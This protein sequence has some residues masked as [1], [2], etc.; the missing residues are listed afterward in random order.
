M[1]ENSFV[2][3]SRGN[4][5]LFLECKDI[6]KWTHKYLRK[7]TKARRENRTIIYSDES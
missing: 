5:G 7:I 6:N 2:Y 4:K 3:K 1:H